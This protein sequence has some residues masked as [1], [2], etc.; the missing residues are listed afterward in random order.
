MMI[1]VIALIQVKTCANPRS[2]PGQSRCIAILFSFVT[3][4]AQSMFWSCLND[5]THGRVMSMMV[6]SMALVVGT[7]PPGT[8]PR[9][10]GCPGVRER[11][12]PEHGSTGAWAGRVGGVFDPAGFLPSLPLQKSRTGGVAAVSMAVLILLISFPK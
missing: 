10:A 6:G 12:G 9:T 5:L 3:V 8:S 1:A 4:R 11:P 7:L 2:S